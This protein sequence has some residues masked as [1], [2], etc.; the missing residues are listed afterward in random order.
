LSPKVDFILNA[1]HESSQLESGIARA[2]KDSYPPDYF[3][4]YKSSQWSV[5]KPYSV[6]NPNKFG[7]ASVIDYRMHLNHDQRDD[8]E[9][10]TTMLTTIKRDFLT[11]PSIS[12]VMPIFA[13]VY[14]KYTYADIIPIMS[15]IFADVDNVIHV[16]LS[17]GKLAR[18]PRYLGIIGSRSLNKTYHRTLTEK[19]IEQALTEWYLKPTDFAAYV[20]GGADGIDKFGC[21][22]RRSDISYKESIASMFGV[23]GVIVLP[24]YDKYGRSATFVRNVVVADIVTHCVA[25]IDIDSTTQGTRHTLTQI[26]NWNNENPH[27]KKRVKLVEVSTRQTSNT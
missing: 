5:D 25:L 20:S 22:R 23:T 7:V 10:L 17:P 15:S 27:A 13:G 26:R 11:H 16:G 18:P 8:I 14:G 21:G 1:V 24:N 2:I 12:M 19:T 3:D 4:A 9:K 6:Y